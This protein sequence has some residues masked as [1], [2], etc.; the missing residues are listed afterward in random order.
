MT[1][2]AK[3]LSENADTAALVADILYGDSYEVAKS[4]YSEAERRKALKETRTGQAA[5]VLGLTGSAGAIATGGKVLRDTYK[6]NVSSQVPKLPKGATLKQRAGRAKKLYRAAMPKGAKGMAVRGAMLGAA[7]NFGLQMADG[8]GDTVQGVVLMRNAN[9]Q[10]REIN[11]MQ[12]GVKKSD[13]GEFGV[14]CEISKV[15]DDKRQVFGWA[16]I[17]K[18]DGMVVT[19]HQ[20]DSID[21]E[22]L[23]KAAYKYMLDSRKGGHEH[24]KTDE[25]P[26]H[27]ADVIESFVV[28]DEKK[29]AMGLPEDVP[30]G[31]WIG[32][33][34]NDDKV[35]E[36]AK[37]GELA[38]FSIHGSG[39][40]VPRSA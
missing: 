1:D 13:T 6:Q 26:L 24:Q 12:D 17:S 9:R 20:G 16:S 19:D 36:L 15:D 28:T 25:G 4:L 10:K 33:K 32:M 8:I 34:V 21:T 11:A 31:W 27:V 2:I 7:G 22:E 29:K 38:G 40:R 30:E 23:E 35:W 39:R 5:N 37:S 14:F 18:K 3:A